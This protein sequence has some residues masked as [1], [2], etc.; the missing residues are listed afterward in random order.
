MYSY[1]KYLQLCSFR[2]FSSSTVIDPGTKEV[3]TIFNNF[4]FSENIST[5]LLNDLIM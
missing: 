3:G 5:L 1:L 2:K 4:P